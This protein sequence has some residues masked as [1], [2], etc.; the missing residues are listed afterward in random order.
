MAELIRRHYALL[1]RSIDESVTYLQDTH[2]MR[3]RSVARVAFVMAGHGHEWRQETRACYSADGLVELVAAA[4][5]A[6]AE[7][8]DR[9]PFGRDLGYGLHHHGAVVTDLDAAVEKQLG[10]GSEIEWELLDDGQRIAV[11]F[12]GVAG[13]PGRLEFVTAQAPPLLDLFAEVDA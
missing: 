11:F 9:G 4:H 8:A 3:F 7:A 12:G 1:V 2:D 6:A 10:H 5:G 13:L